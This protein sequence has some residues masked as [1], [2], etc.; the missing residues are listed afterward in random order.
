MTLPFSLSAA[1][2]RRAVG[3]AALALTAYHSC[4]MDSSLLVGE[5]NRLATMPLLRTLPMFALAGY[6]LA[7][8]RAS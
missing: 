8:S 6:V 4:C 1:L 3:A 2:R 5:L 7:E